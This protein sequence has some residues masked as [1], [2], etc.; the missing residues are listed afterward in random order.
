MAVITVHSWSDFIAA[1]GTAGA[2][3]EFPKDIV[4]T[5]DTDVDP[6]KLYVDSNGI[7]QTNVQPADLPNLYE[8]TFVL[9][10]NL[11][12]DL[13][14]GFTTTITVNCNS[15]NGYGGYIKNAYCPNAALFTIATSTNCVITGIAFLNFAL[16]NNGFLNA[17]KPPK[18]YYCLFSG[19][20]Q[21][22]TGSLLN[23]FGNY[24]GY[25]HFEFQSC[26]FNITLKGS[27]IKM[28]M[29]YGDTQAGLLR[30]CRFECDTSE[31]TNCT[32]LITP[33]NSYITGD[34]T[35]FSSIYI[36]G[37]SGAAA[38][39][40]IWEISTATSIV[41][42]MGCSAML[43]NNELY[44]GTIPAGFSGVSSTD[45]ANAQTLRDTYGFPI[46]T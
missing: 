15:I 33:I 26:S 28:F 36:W 45:L 27:N 10:A 46:Q 19:T 23:F 34:F 20:M 4:R 8:N 14:L 42:Q 12:N 22:T 18:F 29:Q 7:V 11:D 3:V 9:D 43:I 2:E 30:Y 41:L 16:E 1:I 44:T 24:G 13:R 38:Y 5:Q 6:N 39:A 17:A 35:G 40:S 32:L 21:N 25:I 37:A 31:V